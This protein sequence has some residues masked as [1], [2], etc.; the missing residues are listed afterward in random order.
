M[1]DHGQCRYGTPLPRLG[2]ASSCWGEL[3]TPRNRNLKSTI[4]QAPNSGALA[5]EMP[6]PSAPSLFQTDKAHTA[7][8]MGIR[9][10]ISELQDSRVN[11]RN[12]L[13]L[14]SLSNQRGF[15]PQWLLQSGG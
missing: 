10:K 2:A 6:S 3:G 12:L 8:T 4:M 14:Q 7:L 11:L 15:L 1:N 9:S 13:R 5:F